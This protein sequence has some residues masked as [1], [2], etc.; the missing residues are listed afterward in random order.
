M[1]HQVVHTSC[2]F[3]G[4]AKEAAA[5]VIARRAA[6]LNE[7]KD[8]SVSLIEKKTQPMKPKKLTKTNLTSKTSKIP[9]G[10]KPNLEQVRLVGRGFSMTVKGS[11]WLWLQRFLKPYPSSQDPLRHR[12]NLK[13]PACIKLNGLNVERAS[14]RESRDSQQVGH[15]M[16][17]INEAC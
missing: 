10:M 14:N 7:R 13:Y 3:E 8:F 11:S 4:M 12:V 9:K 16:S 5:L 2:Y 6:G 15:A 1:A 17:Q